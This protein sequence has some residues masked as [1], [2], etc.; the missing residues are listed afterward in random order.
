MS[1]SVLP[2]TDTRRMDA[3]C[4]TAQKFAVCRQ[5]SWPAE[6]TRIDRLDRL[7]QKL[8]SATQL[9]GCR[10]RLYTS[11]FPLMTT[12]VGESPRPAISV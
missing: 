12:S 1:D 9:S 3:A 8:T 10:Q 7:R 4:D 11:T 2:L 5:P 6:F